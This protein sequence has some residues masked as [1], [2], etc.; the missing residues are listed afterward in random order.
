MDGLELNWTE[1]RKRKKMD[2]PK[3]RKWTVSISSGFFSKAENQFDISGPSIF[4]LLI[5]PDGPLLVERPSTLTH[6][7]PLRL[8]KP[9]TM[10]L[11]V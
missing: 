3:D 4:T 7:R 5:L 9:S 6:D 1:I 8:K 2:G 11:D 10:V